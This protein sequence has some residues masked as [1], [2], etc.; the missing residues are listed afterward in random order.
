M[1]SNSAVAIG[2]ASSVGVAL[3][4]VAGQGRHVGPA[5]EAGL[6]SRSQS[7]RRCPSRSRW[8]R[9][10]S[11]QKCC[12]QCRLLKP[13]SIP[14]WP[15]PSCQRSP[16]KHHRPTVPTRPGSTRSARQR[17][18]RPVACETLPP[19]LSQAQSSNV[20]FALRSWLSR[21]FER[22]TKASTH[23]GSNWLRAQRTISARARSKSTPWR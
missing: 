21:S 6:R 14:R 11:I 16:R 3:H 2:A 20:S 4:A 12:C 10:W 9:R 22:L 23:S 8:S 7:S 13:W 1:S 17:H 15:S 18:R 5:I 19:P